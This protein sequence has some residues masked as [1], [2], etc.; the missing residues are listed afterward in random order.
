MTFVDR[1][2]K[3]I[4]VPVVLADINNDNC[5]DI[6]ATA[7]AGVLI[8]YDGDTFQQIWSWTD[9]FSESYT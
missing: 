3:G 5:L 4:M 8:A 6:I 2:D 1:S 7:F 9:K